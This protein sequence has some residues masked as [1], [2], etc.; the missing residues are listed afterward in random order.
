MCGGAVASASW[1][2]VVSREGLLCARSGRCKIHVLIIYESDTVQR[3]TPHKNQCR[4]SENIINIY[5]TLDGTGLSVSDRL[6][7]HNTIPAVNEITT[8][9]SMKK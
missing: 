3:T 1:N 4:R 9:T 7:R 6:C 5:T 2:W 8:D